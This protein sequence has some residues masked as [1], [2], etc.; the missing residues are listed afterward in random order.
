M[1]TNAVDTVS[2]PGLPDYGPNGKKLAEDMLEI[3][4]ARLSSFE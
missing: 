2:L 1:D 3:V 4:R